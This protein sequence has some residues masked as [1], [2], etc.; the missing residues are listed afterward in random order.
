[1]C[2]VLQHI[3]A[4][5]AAPPLHPQLMALHRRRAGSAPAQTYRRLDHSQG[6]FGSPL[7]PSTKGLSV[8]PSTPRAGL[9]DMPLHLHRTMQHRLA[10]AS[11]RPVGARAPI[12]TA[13]RFFSANTV[14]V[15]SPFPVTR[16]WHRAGFLVLPTCPTTSGR[17]LC[18]PIGTLPRSRCWQNSRWDQ[19]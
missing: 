2:V 16:Y 5:G 12:E 19:A 15:G 13:R 9:G 8:P 17:P 4:R 6:D 14:A 7:H 10:G 11:P 18:L 1:M 3:L